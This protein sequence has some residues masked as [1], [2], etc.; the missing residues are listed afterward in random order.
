MEAVEWNDPSTDAIHHSDPFMNKKVWVRVI[1]MVSCALSIVGSLLIIVS[2]F[3]FKDLRSLGR[4]ILVHISAMDLGVAIANLVGAAVYFD[5]FYHF[6]TDCTTKYTPI[7]APNWRSENVSRNV[8]V[9]CPE[10]GTIE[11]L[12]ISQAFF[13]CYFTYAS[14]LWTNSLSCYLYFRIVHNGTNLAKYSLHFSYLFCYLLPLFLSVWLLIVGKLGYSP[15]ESSGWCS[16]VLKDPA[17]PTR[18]DIFVSIFGYNL[19]IV[20]TFVLVPLLSLSVHFHVRH[21]VSTQLCPHTYL[22][23]L[24]GIASGFKACHYASALRDSSHC[25]SVVDEVFIPL[26]CEQQTSFQVVYH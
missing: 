10:S 5:R 2:F 18:R 17:D 25:A 13:S 20:L 19:W 15:Y 1:I 3:C 23:L 24:E 12:C 9:M 16:I 4:Q 11:G 22:L 21:E 7:F 6:E 14:I 26:F 8:E